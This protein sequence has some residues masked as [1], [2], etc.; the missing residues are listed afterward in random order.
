[1]GRVRPIGISVRLHWPTAVSLSHGFNNG[2]DW[3]DLAIIS[4][5]PAIAYSDYRNSSV[6]TTYRRANDA[7]GSSW[8]DPMRVGSNTDIND[9][10]HER[11]DLEDLN[12]FPVVYNHNASWDR[13]V[14]SVL[15][16][17]L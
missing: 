5:R 14:V 6:A 12:G 2:Y 13:G 15:E 8:G 9:N 7:N 10:M 1:M 4:G 16:T 11:I 3:H 17:E